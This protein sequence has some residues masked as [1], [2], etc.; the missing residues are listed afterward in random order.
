MIAGLPLA[1]WLAAGC[2]L[3]AYT[4][5]VWDVSWH[6]AI[7]R[8]TFWSPPH[9]ALYAGVGTSLLSALWALLASVRH[10]GATRSGVWRL[11]RYAVPV[12]F[13]FAAVGQGGNV[14]TAPLDDLWHRLYGRDVDIWSVPHL[15]ALGCSAVGSL[16]WLTA[17]APYLRD[18]A[19]DRPRAAPF[20]VYCV[21][22]GLLGY[23]GWFGLNWYHILAASRDAV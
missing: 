14:L 23:T 16:G 6:R 11:G 4:G 13:L 7:G 8:D 20:V 10:P 9:L 3:L 2:G 15:L 12:G 21:F 22:L 5:A 1:M 19:A 17:T 18:R